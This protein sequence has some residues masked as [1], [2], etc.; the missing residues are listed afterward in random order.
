M[1]TTT[2][3]QFQSTLSLGLVASSSSTVELSGSIQQST[4]VGN[5]P[6]TVLFFLA[7]AVGVIIALLFVYFTLRYFVRS[8]YGLHVYSFLRRGS[9]FSN[10]NDRAVPYQP[11]N[12]ELQ[13]HL[14][15]LR[16]HHFL[17]DEFL[18]RR[19][20]GNRRRRRRR[21]RFAKMKKLT[22]E[23]VE[24]LFPK[25]SYEEWMRT[26]SELTAVE[27]V[28]REGDPGSPS[29]APEIE[30]TITADISAP[31]GNTSVIELRELSHPKNEL[32]TN[33]QS[34]VTLGCETT[35]KGE[36]HFDSGLCA[37]CLEIY[38]DDDVVRG[39]VCGHVFHSDCVDPW[40]I[41]R[42]ACCPICKRDYYRETGRGDAETG[43]ENG[44][45][46]EATGVTSDPA[47]GENTAGSDSPA[48]AVDLA[49]QNDEDLINYE[50]LRNDP[51]LQALLQ[52]LVP[53]SERVRVI[54]QE[55]PDLDLE[56]RAHE[57]A[58]IKRGGLLRRMI[59]RLMGISYTDI[60]HWAV[61]RL[62][63]DQMIAADGQ[64]AQENT[65]TLATGTTETA[66]A[67][68]DSSSEGDI[69]DN[70]GADG[71]GQLPGNPQTRAEPETQTGAVASPA[72]HQ[73]R[74]GSLTPLPMEDAEEDL[75]DATRRQMVDRMV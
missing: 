70:S 32:L 7:L 21:G 16:T 45:E 54:L 35:D 59:W 4:F 38:E 44:A 63:Q 64:D 29:A 58:E 30:E 75:S 55:H 50:F 73:L 66:D 10:R 41:R 51:N 27:P 3:L 33:T 24:K 53:L 25:T 49:Q 5:T 18:E 42:R 65:G 71:D 34:L 67:Q 8:R 23:E 9:F 37:I 11:L 40:L 15:Y 69:V 22:A 36:L 74:S 26:G 39:L 13:E 56:A 61:I 52:E 60:Y 2:T 47:S 17:R 31:P 43:P 14:N 20:M 1:S 68:P 72:E 6:S 57:L 28:V 12:R 48:D 19:L 46:A 62:Y